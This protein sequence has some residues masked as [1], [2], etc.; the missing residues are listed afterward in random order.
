MIGTAFQDLIPNNHCFGC[1]PANRGGLQLKSYWDEDGSSVARFVP[2]PH[3]C[4]GPPHFVNGGILATLADCHSVCTAMA[5][6][7]R[8]SGRLLGEPPF[9]HYATAGLSLTYRRPTPIDVPIELRARIASASGK[10]YVVSCSLSAAGKVTVEATVE[11]VSVPPDWMK[12]G[13]RGDSR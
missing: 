5:E 4:A 3:H 2:Q 9:V 11:A 1:G 12:T 7:S 6:A 10:A 13:K 8:A